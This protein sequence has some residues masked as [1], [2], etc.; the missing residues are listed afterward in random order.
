MSTLFWTRVRDEN[1]WY[2]GYSSIGKAYSRNDRVPRD[3]KWDGV[4]WSG[5][6]SLKWVKRGSEEDPDLE[7]TWV[8]RSRSVTRRR[9]T[10]LIY[11]CRGV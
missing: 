4:R 10:S 1:T 2:S 6:C 9:G 7:K 3:N 5:S 11:L 8:V